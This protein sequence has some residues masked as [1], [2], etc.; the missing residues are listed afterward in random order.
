MTSLTNG[1]GLERGE[2][3]LGEFLLSKS[4]IWSAR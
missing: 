2:C 3:G 1:L 4:I